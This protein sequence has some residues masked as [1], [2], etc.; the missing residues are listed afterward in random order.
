LEFQRQIH[1]YYNGVGINLGAYSTP[2]Y[3]AGPG[4]KTVA[5]TQWNCQNYL[6]ADLPGQW[7]AV[8]IP[9]YA[10]PAYG[11]DAEM[12][13]Y[14]P[15]SDTMWE[16]WQA[17]QAGGKWQPCWG[18]KMTGVSKNEGIWP[19]RYGVAATG[20]PF[21]P[22]QITVEE[23]KRGSIRH[24]M[25]IALVDAEKSS[26]FSWPANRSDG[27]NPQNATNRIPEGLR[28]RLDPAVNVDA[29]DL[30][31]V[32]KTIAKAAQ[33][34]G[35]TSLKTQTHFPDTCNVRTRPNPQSYRPIRLC[36]ARTGSRFPDFPCNF[37]LYQG[38]SAETG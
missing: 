13:I 17:R 32:A 23:L 25:G 5:V 29:L 8:P 4:A 37:P 38:S 10:R 36:P 6:D 35:S 3:V 20:L 7:A 21:A 22:G 33:I 2:I 18:G 16:F 15:S 11:T 19:Q 26:V 31:P 9:A 30:S 14:Q 28:F 1:A 34:P 24:V 27:Y 12:T